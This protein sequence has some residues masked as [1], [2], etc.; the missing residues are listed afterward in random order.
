MLFTF[1]PL[2]NANAVFVVCRRL[3]WPLFVCPWL[4][5]IVKSLHSEPLCLEIEAGERGSAQPYLR[6]PARLPS[7]SVSLSR[8]D[9]VQCCSRVQ[10]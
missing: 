4:A 7:L 3:S 10:C 1:L 8:A 9:S 5:G 6:S 2:K